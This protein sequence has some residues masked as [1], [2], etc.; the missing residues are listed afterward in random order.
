[1]K[2]LLILALSMATLVVNAQGILKLKSGN[3]KVPLSFSAID[4]TQSN[5]GVLIWDK[6]ITN[7]DLQGSIAIGIDLLNYLPDNSYEVIIPK[8]VSIQQLKSTGAKGFIPLIGNMKLDKPLAQQD[9]PSWAWDGDS[10]E[11]RVLIYHGDFNNT[12]FE[13]RAHLSEKENWYNLKLSPIEINDL[14]A[15]HNVRFV[16]AKEEKG[17]PENDN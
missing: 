5:L 10:L 8:N 6:K 13:N 1:M 4:L 9:F 17:I 3:Y 16:Q 12:I 2:K 15:L 11:I 14:V 7:Q